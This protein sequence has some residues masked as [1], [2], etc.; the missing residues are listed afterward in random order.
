MHPDPITLSVRLPSMPD[1]PEWKLNGSIIEIPDMPVTYMVSTLRDR[2]V[3]IVDAP[4]PMSKMQ[5][6]YG[7]LNLKNQATLAATNLDDGDLIVLS[8][9]DAKKR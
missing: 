3:K 8:M 2:I 4:L 9:K 6:A 5:L 1:K 7:N